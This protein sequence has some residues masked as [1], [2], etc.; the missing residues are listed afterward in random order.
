VLV[1]GGIYY[2]IDPATSASPVFHLL[3]GGT[4]LGAFF[5]MT[6]TSSSPLGQI[7]MIVFGLTGGALLILI[8]TYGQYPDGI[9]FAVLL[10]NMTTPLVDLIKP[11]PF[12]AR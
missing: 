8:R 6:D 9:A 2:A 5:L 1:I 3:T 10:A 7:P 11:K 4:M 12:G